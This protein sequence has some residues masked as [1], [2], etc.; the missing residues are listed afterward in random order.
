[1]TRRQSIS[2]GLVPVSIG[3]SA[4]DRAPVRLTLNSAPISSFWNGTNLGD[5]PAQG[6]GPAA[7]LKG[8]SDNP[9]IS[10]KETEYM[11]VAGSPPLMHRVRAALRAP[12][13][14]CWLTQWMKRSPR[15]AGSGTCAWVPALRVIAWAP[16]RAR[17]CTPK[18]QRR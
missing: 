11:D 18:P 8:I 13:I 12:L 14:T 6:P 15:K 17:L 4:F 1:M 9:D 3:D 2:E 5:I 16:G 10:K 7:A